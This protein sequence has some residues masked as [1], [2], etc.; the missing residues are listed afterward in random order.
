MTEARHLVCKKPSISGY[1]EVKQTCLHTKISRRYQSVYYTRVPR[2]YGIEFSFTSICPEFTTL[3]YT[4][5][6]LDTQPV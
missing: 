6:N 3:R 2:D 1:P 5:K 4:P